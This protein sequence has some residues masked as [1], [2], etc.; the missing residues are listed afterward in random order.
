M[1]DELPLF[2]YL[3]SQVN[4]KNIV[5]ELNMIEDYLKY[6]K[7]VDKESKVLTNIKV[8]KNYYFLGLSF[9]YKQ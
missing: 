9:L 5:V 6:S 7:S 8:Q 3:T 4:V 2:I 1:D